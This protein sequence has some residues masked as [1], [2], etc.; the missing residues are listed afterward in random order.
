[1]QPSH[2]AHLAA[3]SSKGNSLAA[4]C[5]AHSRAASL[6]ATTLR[7]ILQSLTHDLLGPDVVFEQPLPLMLLRYL[8]VAMAL[9]ERELAPDGALLFARAAVEQVAAAFDGEQSAERLQREGGWLRGDKCWACCCAPRERS[10]CDD[11]HSAA[12]RVVW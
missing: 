10:S 1:M 7:S 3:M 5:T 8:E 11:G 6:P 2:F 4:H 12:A 9:L